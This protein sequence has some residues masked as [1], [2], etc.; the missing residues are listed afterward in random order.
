MVDG[1]KGGAE[2]N[3]DENGEEARVSREKYVIGDFQ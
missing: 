1:I 3:E 2:V